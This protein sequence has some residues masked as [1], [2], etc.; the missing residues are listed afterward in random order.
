MSAI[1]SP[2]LS[3]ASRVLRAEVR[4][5]D[6]LIELEQRRLGGRL[7]DEHVERGAGDDAVADRLGQLLSSTM[8]PRAT[9]ITPQRRLG[10]EQAG[11]D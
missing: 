1:V 8:P 9:L 11:R 4:G 6:D 7:G 5:D 10:L 3:C 2:A